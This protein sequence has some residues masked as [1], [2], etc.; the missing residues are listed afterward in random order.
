M[1]KDLLTLGDTVELMNSNDYR[2]RF[3]AEYIQTALRLE[4]LTAFNQRLTAADLTQN[5]KLEPKHDCPAEL[6]FDQEDAMREYLRILETRAVIEEID[7]ADAIASLVRKHQKPC[8]VTH[9][10]KC[11]HGIYG[12][13]TLRKKG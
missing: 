3:V 2:D 10:I 6:L 5:E 1:I 11:E 4:K 9:E 8:C 13:T 12:E 7:L